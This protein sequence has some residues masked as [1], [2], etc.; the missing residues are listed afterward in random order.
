[1]VLTQSEKE[2]IKNMKIFLAH[3]LK[4]KMSVLIL[5]KEI[6]QTMNGIVYMNL[7]IR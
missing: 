1:M 6:L 4:I 2:Q 7:I 3:V 5:L